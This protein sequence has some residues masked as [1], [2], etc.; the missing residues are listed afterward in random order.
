MI[1]DRLTTGILPVRLALLLIIPWL[2]LGGPGYEASRSFKEAWNLGHVLLF[3]LLAIECERG[4]KT[5]IAATG[6]RALAIM[7]LLLSA[8]V[9][10]E[11]VQ[12]LFPGRI[13]SFADVVY[14]IAGALA[15]TSLAL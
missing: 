14:S 11:I 7:V 8:A 6:T 13:M 15:A 3:F 1:K 2:F 10:I 9:L 5:K 4:L 12:S